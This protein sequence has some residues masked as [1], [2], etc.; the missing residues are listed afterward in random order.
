MSSARAP[1][2]GRRAAVSCMVWIGLAVNAASAQT[3]SPAATAFSTMKSLQGQWTI[4]RD[5]K[6][7]PFIMTYDIASRG[8][9]VTEQ[10]GRELSVFYLDGNRLL[11]THF[12]NAGNQPR[13]QL[14]MGAAAGVLD[15]VMVDITG[16]HDPKDAHVREVIYQIVDAHTVKLSLIWTGDG[17]GAPEMYTLS[18]RL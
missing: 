4:V 7:R 6:P 16:L 8:S 1:M 18:R 10:F 12:C 17:S 15:F 2:L 14:R 3:A 11:M 13:L 9:I 5:G